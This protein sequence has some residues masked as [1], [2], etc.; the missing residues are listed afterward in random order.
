MDE[1]RFCKKCGH[2]LVAGAEFCAYCGTPVSKEIEVI[3]KP[4]KTTYPSS[5]SG[6]TNET[7]CPH[8]GNAIPAESKFCPI[9]Q[10]QLIAACP[11]CGHVYPALYPNC[12][13]C[14]TNRDQY[15]KELELAEKKKMEED[16]KRRQAQIEQEMREKQ[17]TSDT[18]VVDRDCIAATLNHLGQRGINEI[19]R[20]YVK[21]ENLRIF[22]SAV[23][24]IGV[25][26]G[27]GG[28]VLSAINGNDS[29]VGISIVILVIGIIAYLIASGAKKSRDKLSDDLLNVIETFRKTLYGQ[30]DPSGFV[31]RN[32]DFF[33]N[34]I[35]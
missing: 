11:K 13:A 25:L 26:I 17:R 31:R 1:P 4:P 27:L 33:S 6:K 30:S 5:H 7:L 9:C 18:R 2:E 35:L 22:F 3:S 21:Y 23:G 15:Q 10:T 34:M 14:G 24:L 8:C 28:T 19:Q 20:N 16:E 32:P 12:N 29:G